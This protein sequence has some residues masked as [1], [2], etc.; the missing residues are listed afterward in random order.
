MAFGVTGSKFD[1]RTIPESWIFLQDVY[2][3]PFGSHFQ[4]E[5]TILNLISKDTPAVIIENDSILVTGDKLLQNL[6]PPR[7][8]RVQRQIAH[9]GCSYRGIK[10]NW[11]TGN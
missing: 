7:G 5:E 11:R 2:N 10:T 1:V 6:R 9:D 4:G 8:C 3:V